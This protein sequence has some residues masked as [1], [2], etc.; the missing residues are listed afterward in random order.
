MEAGERRVIDPDPETVPIR[1][2]LAGHMS[3]AAAGSV[4]QVFGAAGLGADIGGFGQGA[5]AAHAAVEQQSLDPFF[6]GPQHRRPGSGRIAGAAQPAEQ[7]AGRVGRGKE[8]SVH[9][10]VGALITISSAGPERR[11]PF[12]AGSRFDRLIIIP[13]T[14]N[15]EVDIPAKVLPVRF[16]FN[17]FVEDEADIGKIQSIAAEMDTGIPKSLENADHLCR[18]QQAGLPVTLS[19]LLLH[20]VDELRGK[21][22]A[23]NLA[24]GHV[25]CHSQGGDK[26]V[27]QD[28]DGD[29]VVTEKEGKLLEFAGV[30]TQLGNDKMGTGPDFVQQLGVL[31]DL[32][33]LRHLEWRDDTAAVEGYGVKRG[34]PVA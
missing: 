11:L 15:R 5:V 7:A 33:G 23:G 6:Q 14:G 32:L 22:N 31:P 2:D 34:A 9:E 25:P 17:G 13:G 3:A 10:T 4:E 24:P 21:D 29:I 28:R 12:A 27:G 8:Q 1:V 18:T 19:F 16:Q 30:K 20:Q 26:D